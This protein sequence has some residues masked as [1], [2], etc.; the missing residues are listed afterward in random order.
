MPRGGAVSNFTAIARA[1]GTRPSDSSEPRSDIGG[2]LRKARPESG[3]RADAW[4]GHAGLVMLTVVSPWGVRKFVL[5]ATA[6]SRD[7]VPSPVTAPG[8]TTVASK[9]ELI[10]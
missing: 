7:G 8:A 10:P 4:R 3:E 5:G 6:A 2:T 9:P 1:D